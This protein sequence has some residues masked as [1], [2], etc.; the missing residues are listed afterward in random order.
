MSRLG[1]KTNRQPETTTDESVARLPRVGRRLYT[2]FFW[3]YFLL[4]NVVMFPGA[5][6]LFVFIAP[7]DRKRH[8]QHLYS[9]FWA[10]TYFYVN[11]F[12]H[13]KIEGR[14]NLPRHHAAVL[15][16][17]HESLGDILALFGLYSPFKWISKASVFRVPLLGWNMYFSGYIPVTRGD[18][19]SIQEMMATCRDWLERN[20]PVLF[21][22]EGTRSPDGTVSRFKDGAF[23]LAIETDSPVVP[24]A[25]TGMADCLPKH[26]R[27]LGL[28]VRARISVLEPVDTSSFN[29][30]V[31]A[32]RDHVRKLIVAEKA[33]LTEAA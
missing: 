15:A 20:V 23:Q 6:L 12:W 31:G 27:V 21:F 25:V 10:Q 18:K 7:F 17:N 33:R 29:G 1:D 11:P 14:E 19:R 5:L 24:I 28:S 32:L 4:G 16:S 3:T 26:S 2:I 13:L 8:V 30:D 9:C 22:P